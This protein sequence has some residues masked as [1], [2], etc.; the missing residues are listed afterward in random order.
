MGNTYLRI[1]FPA[2]K[3][4]YTEHCPELATYQGR[5]YDIKSSKSTRKI[6]YA[7]MPCFRKESK[8]ELEARCVLFF[9]DNSEDVGDCLPMLAKV[10]DILRANVFAVEYPGYG[11]N[12]SKASADPDLIKQDSLDMFD[13]LTTKLGISPKDILVFGR[14]IGS[15]AACYLSGKYPSVSNLLLLSPIFSV[16]R[17][18]NDKIKW[19]SHLVSITNF[20]N[21]V[22][23]V[24]KTHARLLVVHGMKDDVVPV[25]HGIDLVQVLALYYLRHTTATDRA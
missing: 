9:H 10:R 25:Q 5:I 2:G 18:V 24:R 16:E 13:F 21:N 14:S 15:G 11:I 17:I 22:E 12:P 3:S 7:F 4:S 20:F 1:F 23:E 19:G 6:I 8:E